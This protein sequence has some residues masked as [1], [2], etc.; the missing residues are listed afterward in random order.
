MGRAD[1][2]V[3]LRG[4]LDDGAFLAFWL[5]GQRITA[6]MNVNIWDVADQIR[7]LILTGKPADAFTLPSS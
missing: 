2:D 4:A 1:D 5:G 3:I 7:E 6:A